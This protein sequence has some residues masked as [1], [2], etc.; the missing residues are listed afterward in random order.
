[1][2]GLVLVDEDGVPVRH[3]MSY[4]D[5]RASEEMKEGIGKGLKVA[6]MNAE[7]LMPLSS[8]ASFALSHSKKSL[9]IS[10]MTPLL[11]M[12]NYNKN[13]KMVIRESKVIR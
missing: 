8:A 5:Q 6:G 3:P 2:Q 12:F 9:I 10:K 7:K 11:S 13:Y 4:M 1:M